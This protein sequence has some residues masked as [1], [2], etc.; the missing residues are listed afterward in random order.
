METTE[1]FI[2]GE[3]LHRESCALPA[4]VYNRAHLLLAGCG[5]ECI[6]VPIRSMQYLAVI[7]AEAIIFVDGQGARRLVALAWR[8]FQPQSRETLDDPVPYELVL[9]QPRA[10]DFI[11]R[12]QSEFSRALR[13]TAGKQP[14]P[15]AGGPRVLPF[16]KD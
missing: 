10:S 7:D 3:E 6:F 1:D 13:E 12:L 4:A 15:D 2:F 5:R 11:R 8:H 9:Y 16:R 14:T